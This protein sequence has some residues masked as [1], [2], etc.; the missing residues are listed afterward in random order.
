MNGGCLTEEEATPTDTVKDILQINPVDGLDLNLY[1]APGETNDHLI[2]WW[3]AE[4]ILF[5]GDN[6]YQVRNS[7]SLLLLRANLS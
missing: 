6:I 5:P 4:R 2:V 1:H 7:S 3:P